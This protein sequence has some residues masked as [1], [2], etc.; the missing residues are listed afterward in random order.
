[1][2]FADPEQRRTYHR[3]YKR[4]RR[5][6]G[7]AGSC[8]TLGQTLLPS[9]FRVRTARDVLELLG[10]QVAAVLADPDVGTLERARTVGFLAGLLLKAVES[11]DVAARLEAVERVLKRRTEE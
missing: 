6:G 5:S 11:A 2:P 7:A 1:M 3:H 10:G 8:P 4:H 9:P